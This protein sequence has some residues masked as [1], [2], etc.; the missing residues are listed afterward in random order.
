MPSDGERHLFIT[1]FNTAG[2]DLDTKVGIMYNE[3]PILVH[4][5]TFVPINPNDTDGDTIAFDVS[6]STD[7]FSSDD[8]EIAVAAAVEWNDT[9]NPSYPT[10][11]VGYDI[12]LTTASLAT[13][14]SFVRVAAGSVVAA[15]ITITGAPADSRGYLVVEYSVV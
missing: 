8:N 13:G 12:P 2:G 11:R 6:A 9:D 14:S 4:A 1:E 3:R 7:G 15:T 10:N 5:V